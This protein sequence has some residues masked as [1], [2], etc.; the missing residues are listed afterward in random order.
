SGTE[1]KAGL[2]CMP[3]GKSGSPRCTRPCA[4]VGASSACMAGT[5][6][7]DIGGSKYCVPPD[8]GKPCN[9]AA[10]CHFACLLA[11]KHCTG[12]CNTGADC[13]NGW[14]C[15]PV[16]GTKVCV[17]AAEA[18]DGVNNAA[19]VVPAACDLSANL[20]VGSCT[21]AC[22]SP[23]DCPQRALGMS[24]WSCDG[25]CRRPS[26]GPTAIYGPLEGGTAP[27]QWA[28]NGFNQVVN[29]CGDGQHIDFNAFTI[30]PP[31]AVSCSATITTDGVAGDACVDS[32]RYAGGCPFGFQCVAVGSVA[33]NSRIGLCLPGFGS[34]QVGGTCSRDADCF[35]GY[36]NRTAGKCSRDC[37]QDGLCPTGSACVA[38]G[39]PTVEGL[40]FRRCQ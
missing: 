40:P 29:V 5:R 33:A 10:D 28:C 34:V 11:T 25:L 22:S 6:C 21:L 23:A 13:P 16:G 19:C 38:G 20:V 9:V 15:M 17:K 14:G 24:P 4:Q 26:S 18:C 27:S 36:C 35:F 31:P 3:F 7:E 12:S 2:I 39:G 32:C 37:S 8:I 1:C 30:P